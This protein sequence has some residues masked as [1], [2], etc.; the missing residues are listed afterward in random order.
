[1]PEGRIL[2]LGQGQALSAVIE[3]QL[4]SLDRDSFVIEL[5]G[6]AT[7][8]RRNDALHYLL[9]IRTKLR[10]IDTLLSG[11]RKEP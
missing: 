10:A 1:M 6:Q 5:N 9:A 11:V 2:P 4:K 7:V 8:V 3:H